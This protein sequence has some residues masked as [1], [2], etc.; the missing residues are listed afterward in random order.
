MTKNQLDFSGT[1]IYCGIDVHKKSWRVNIQDGEFELEDFTQSPDPEVLNKHLNRRY[2]NATFKIGYEAGF[3]GFSIQRALRNLGKDCLVINAAD[4]PTS[5]KEKRQK[6]DKIDA[7]KLCH[8]LQTR[9]AKSVYVPEMGMEH[10]RTLVRTRER[11]VNTQTRCKNRIWH[12]LHF[13]GLSLPEACEEGRYWSKRFVNHLLKMDCGGSP[14]LKQSLE[15]YIKEHLHTRE[16]LHQAIM[17]IRETCKLEAHA[18][19]IRILRTIP[20]IG[21]VNAAV[22]LFELQDIRRFKRFDHLCSYAGLI[23]ET[24]DSG[25]TKRT[26]GIT[27]RRNHHLRVALVESS[28]SVVRKDPALLM[29][30]K[31]YCKRMEKN[32]A[33]I[34]IAKHL[35]ARINYV[36]KNR[37]EYVTGVIS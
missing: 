37:T 3:C 29:K 2:P 4:I 11:L 26:R 1:I 9:K 35:L 34:R 27:N 36:L 30:Y 25:D 23:P 6:Q 24:S 18:E 5:D 20:G 28:W 12:L 7:R 16:L 15:L 32:K 33:I 13:S 31:K 17:A 21:E 14:S 8:H 22:I 10:V 19:S